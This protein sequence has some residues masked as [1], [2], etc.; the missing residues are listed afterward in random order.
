[1]YYLTE[2]NDS[3]GCKRTDSVTVTVNSFPLATTSPNTT[4][5][6]GD[7]VAVGTTSTKGH[8]YRWT[9]KPVGFISNSSNPV[10]RPKTST[11][12]YLRESNDLT[13]CSKTDSVKITVNPL[14]ATDAGKDVAIC[15]GDPVAI[16]SVGSGAY[17]YHW[18]SRPK[19]FIS[20]LANPVVKPTA[21][22]SYFLT[23][24]NTTTGCTKNDTVTI[25][26]HSRPKVSGYSA[27]LDLCK[28]V[29]HTISQAKD[30]NNYKYH[31]RLSKGRD[32]S[33]SDTSFATFLWDKE[34]LDTV[35]AVA[36]NTFG[37]KDSARYIINIH[38]KPEGHFSAHGNGLT[39]EFV[40]SDTT[41]LKYKWN[42]GDSSAIDSSGGHVFHTF[43]DSQSYNVSVFERSG[44]DCAN[45]FD[46]I[47]NTKTGLSELIGTGR[48]KISIYP[49]PFSNNTTISYTLEKASQV[50]I[51]VI[52]IQGRIIT[53]L[54]QGN[55]P[56]GQH[57]A[58]F[59]AGQYSCP[60]G[61]YLV[62]ITVAGELSVNRIVRVE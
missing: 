58:E 47:I 26:V 43:P 49:N 7:S 24:T 57:T 8:S 44:I 32:I 29:I 61:V 13:G 55:E 36:E 14:P 62:K 9:S 25:T 31:W 37:C 48:P 3:S 42:F 12:Y 18:A 4:I 1:M 15:L 22:I 21:T 23:V 27:Y 53:T 34:G 60:T 30:T 33:T 50:D 10:L 19:G 5:C 11:V 17:S 52:D 54:V 41:Y 6:E 20:S 45:S 59:N 56:S 28:N 35:W 38:D 46:S 16:G 51:K 40:A 39:F 2:S